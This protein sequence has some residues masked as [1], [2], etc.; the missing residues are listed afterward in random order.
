M[1]NIVKIGAYNFGPFNEIEIDF[2]SFNCWVVQS[3]NK[4]DSGQGSNGG[5]KSCLL[6]IVPICLMG[7]SVQGRDLKN[8]VNWNGKDSYFQVYAHIENNLTK[9]VTKITRK[10][11]NNTRGSELKLLVND[12]VPLDIPSKKG[13]ENGV[14]VK[15]GTKYIL[16]EILDIS[17]DDLL[18]YYLISREKYSPFMRIGNSGKIGVISRFSQSDKI[19]QAIE[20]VK[21]E[22]NAKNLSFRELEDEEIR[23][24][25]KIEFIEKE[26]NSSSKES[27][28]KS[29]D[30][31]I[32]RLEGNIER[33]KSSI[34]LLES[35]IGKLNSQIEDEEKKKRDLVPLDF[36]MQ[37]IKSLQQGIAKRSE[38][39]ELVKNELSKDIEDE[40]YLSL[41]E[42]KAEFTEKKNGLNENKVEAESII[43]DHEKI[44]MGVIECPNCAH[45]FLVN[46]EITVEQ[47]CSVIDE[48]EEI[49]RSLES[50]IEVMD[51]YIE[52]KSNAITEYENVFDQKRQ[53]YRELLNLLT[54]EN[55]KDWQQLNHFNSQVKER[56][57]EING[58]DKLIQSLGA[59]VDMKNNLI[60]ASNKS[61][62]TYI[63]AI[64]GVKDKAYV[65][66]DPERKKAIRDLKKDLKSIEK[67]KSA[68]NKEISFREQWV[69]NFEDF[70]F[71]LA[72][73]PIQFICEKVNSCLSKIESDLFVK[74]DGFRILRT[75]KIKQELTPMV[76]RN[77][78]NPQPY[79]QYS[80]GERVRID[81]ATDNSFQE[82]INSNSKTGGLNYYQNDE[83][84][85]ELDSLGVSLVAN[86]FN[87]YNKTMLL[88]THSGADLNHKNVIRIEKENDISS[89]V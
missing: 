38:D 88:V 81:I 14:D 67:S 52:E 8:Y 87:S 43:V 40:K 82:I 48:C 79:K 37:D 71:Y 6:D 62:E 76:Y 45:K 50:D 75:G 70:K 44:L 13:V 58:I 15:A 31:E 59:E 72:N 7:T 49:L 27:F 85:S 68:I 33:E 80:G 24:N 30:E 1:N 41:K 61:I 51:L 21:E 54:S 89:I 60:E 36:S 86:S 42:N 25:T 22:V 65:N 74:I 19:D 46:E 83:V 32:A 63:F 39:I 47:A 11:Y 18:S 3:H 78:M 34:S 56:E 20:E 64:L 9:T 4:T 5:G 55:T 84:L 57:L 26:I 66:K 77:M 23:T 2:D 28:D 17:E 16:N 35:E 53:E 73:R 29:K 12:Q 69:S 10:F